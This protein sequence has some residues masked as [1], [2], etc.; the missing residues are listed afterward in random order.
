M[1][2]RHTP[3]RLILIAID[4]LILIGSLYITLFVRTFGN[5]ENEYFFSFFPSF[6]LIILTSLAIF[7]MYGLYDKP[8][9]R[10]IRELRN[11]II[12]SQI[13]AGIAAVLYFYSLPSLGIAPKTILFIYIT[14]A[15]CAMIIWRYYASLFVIR[16]RKQNS[17]IIGSGRSFHMLVDE[18]ARNPH[19]G[20]TLVSVIDLDTYDTSKIGKV[21]ESTNPDSLIVDLRDSRIKEYFDAMSKR[22][23]EGG[24]VYDIIDVFEDVF[25]MVP[26][27]ILN[28]E[29]VFRHI[30]NAHRVGFIK[31]ALDILLCIPAFAV[32]CI[33]FPFAYI[34]VKLED[35][36]PFLYSHVRIGKY[37]IPF[38]MYKIRSMEHKETNELN[39]TKKITK[40]GSFLRKTR[41]DELPQLW[42]VLRGDVSLIGPRPESP[43]LVEEYSKTIPFYSMRHI[44]RPGLSGW[45]QIQQREAPKFGV[46]IH[47]TSTKLA[48]DIYYLEHEDIWLDFAIVLKTVKVLLSKSGI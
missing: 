6:T 4:T 43:K 34:A 33:L 1:I 41:I 16:Y 9:L 42:N 44:I 28:Q 15:S 37:G 12:S 22:M 47:Q 13:L 32:A 27:D 39:E 23:W 19:T 48:Y 45:A 20:I 2:L 26:L 5:F 10:L 35:G 30:S 21:F 38:T 17:V 11:R 25:D 46:D 14:I 8:S 7:Y 29:W 31:R 24:A 18:L 36:G 3:R 40:V